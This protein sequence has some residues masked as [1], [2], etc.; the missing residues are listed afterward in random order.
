MWVPIQTHPEADNGSYHALHIHRQ[1][2]IAQRV[3]YYSNMVK[4]IRLLLTGAYQT[5]RD[6]ARYQASNHFSDIGGYHLLHWFS[7]IYHIGSG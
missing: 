4:L 2:Q 5:R 7:G 3:I 1:A 6:E